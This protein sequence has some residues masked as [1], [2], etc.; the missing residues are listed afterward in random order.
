MKGKIEITATE[1]GGFDIAVDV[2]HLNVLD[3]LALL[4]GLAQ[5]LELDET[6]KMIAG[7]MF[8]RGGLGKMPG[9]TVQMMGINGGLIQQMMGEN[10]D[11]N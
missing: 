7:I 3:T 11:D 10:K 6:D 9:L 5:A 2:E 8:A 4:D 1:D